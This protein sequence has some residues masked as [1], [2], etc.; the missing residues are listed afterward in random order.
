MDWNDEAG[1]RGEPRWWL[2]HITARLSRHL[3]FPADAEAR[4]RLLYRVAMELFG[5]PVSEEI[6]DLRRRPRRR[7]PRLEALGA[8]TPCFHRSAAGHGIAPARCNPR[9]RNSASLPADPDAAK[10]PA[11]REWSRLATRSAKT[12]G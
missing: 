12:C 4:E 2:D 3:P 11:H 5:T 9:R 8:Q 7:G 6:N 10:K 1:A